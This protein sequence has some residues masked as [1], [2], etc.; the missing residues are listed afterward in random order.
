[1]DVKPVFAVSKCA[2]KVFS[3]IS[4]NAMSSDPPG[5]I[6]WVVFLHTMH[7]IGFMVNKLWGSAWQFTSIRLNVY[8][9][10]QF[11]TCIQRRRYPVRQHD[12]TVGEST[13]LMDGPGRRLK[14]L[15]E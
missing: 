1:V 9:S 6:P 7:A 14:V 12:A 8:R 15:K 5:E 10:I 11:L 2:L 3:T 4:F 13:E